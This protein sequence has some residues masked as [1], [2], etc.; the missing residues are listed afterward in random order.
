MS[1]SE[2]MSCFSVRLCFCPR[3]STA[4]WSGLLYLRFP[5]VRRRSQRPPV[6]LGHSLHT[7]VLFK[8]SDALRRSL[9][10][11]VMEV[12][13][14]LFPYG[15]ALAGLKASLLHT[16]RWSNPAADASR[17][18]TAHVPVITTETN[19]T[20]AAAG[21]GMLLFR[22][23]YWRRSNVA[24]ESKGSA[25]AMERRG[26]EVFMANRRSKC[27]APFTSMLKGLAPSGCGA[28]HYDTLFTSLTR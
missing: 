20:T 8:F 13:A 2:M 9:I 18:A 16:L 24:M 10:G 1:N 19:A 25:V 11:C 22:L 21:G 27:N 6:I 12:L 14:R 4:V 26:S 5:A 3:V 7:E 28:A 15:K 17:H 23:M